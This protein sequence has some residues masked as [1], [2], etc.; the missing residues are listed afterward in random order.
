[1]AKSIPLVKATILNLVKSGSNIPKWDLTTFK[2]FYGT[3]PLYGSVVLETK[4]PEEL[5]LAV[6]RLSFG[7]GG[8]DVIEQALLGKNSI[9]GA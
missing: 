8:S 2:D 4:D 9:T 7:G 3:N 6:Q 5:K 1:M